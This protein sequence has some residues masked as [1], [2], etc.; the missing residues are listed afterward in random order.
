MRYNLTPW[1]P[2]ENVHYGDTEDAH[3]FCRL[4][5]EKMRVISVYSDKAIYKALYSSWRAVM[6][7]KR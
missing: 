5:V 3:M 4:P 6:D 1:R 2:C 7:A